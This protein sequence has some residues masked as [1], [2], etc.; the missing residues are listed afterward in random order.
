MGLTSGV[1]TIQG[2]IEKG[3][4]G[5]VEKFEVTKRVIRSRKANET[6]Q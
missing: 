4:N 3:Q 6:I 1:L 5:V 2:P